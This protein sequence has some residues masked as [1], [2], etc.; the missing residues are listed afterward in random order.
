[1][2]GDRQPMRLGEKLPSN[3]TAP[4]VPF[5]LADEVNK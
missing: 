5:A 1:L 2:R 3:I 4:P